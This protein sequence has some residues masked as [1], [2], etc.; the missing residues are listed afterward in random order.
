MNLLLDTNIIIDY[1]GQRQPYCKDW[2]KLEA[3]YELGD[4]TLWVSSESFTDTFYRLSST[5]DAHSL[6]NSFLECLDFLRV[7]PVGAEVIRKAA[8]CSWPD[9][10][11]CVINV[12][13]ENVKADVIITRDKKGFKRSRI[14]SMDIPGLFEYLEAEYGVVYDVAEW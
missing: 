8:E 5:I 12:C 13:A 1:I 11:D 2:D 6:Q 7:C 9:F 3:M 14:P 10:E 4:A